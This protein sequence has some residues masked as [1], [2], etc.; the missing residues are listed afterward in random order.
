MAASKQYKRFLEGIQLNPKSGL[1]NAVLGDLEVGL[2][3]NRLHFFG[4][5]DD[6]VTTDNVTTTLTNKTLD[7][8]I[9]INGVTISGGA[10]ITGGLIVDTITGQTGTPLVIT[11]DTAQNLQLVVSGGGVINLDGFT[12]SGTN[13]FA[14][15]GTTATFQNNFLFN[16]AGVSTLRNS[17]AGP[18]LITTATNQSLLLVGNGTGFV[19]AEQ[20]KITSNVMECQAGAFNIQTIGGNNINISADTTGV[21]NFFTNGANDVRIQPA[22]LILRTAGVFHFNN[23]ANTFFTGITSDPSSLANYIITL[24]AAAPAANTA[25]S[26]NGANYVWGSLG[27]PASGVTASN[28]G[29]TFLT[30]TDVQA[31]LDETD[32]ELVILS[33]TSSKEHSWELNGNYPGLTFPLLNIDSVFLAQ[34]NLTILAVWIYNGTAGGAGTTEYDLK[35]ASPGGGFATIL[36]TTGKITSAA[37]A[38]IWTDSGAVV[39]PQTGVTKPVLSTTS[40]TAGQAIKFD[41]LQSQTTTATDARIRIVY[42]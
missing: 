5:V 15:S 12:I 13:I 14:T 20:V 11:A 18:F 21:I 2:G 34:R 4:T 9:V 16:S 22:T 35:V 28:I 29:H 7:A 31:Q 24:P 39:A 27:G 38:N 1:V 40:I 37:A 42:I 26:F 8:P 10:N 30:G 41:L 17:N 32:A 23:S 25:L 6:K 3:D 36:S 19:Q 33:N